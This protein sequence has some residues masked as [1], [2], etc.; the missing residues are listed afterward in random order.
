MQG[1]EGTPGDALSTTEV[2]RKSKTQAPGQDVL[3]TVQDDQEVPL[4]LRHAML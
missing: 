3:G 2:L 1:Q 4:E